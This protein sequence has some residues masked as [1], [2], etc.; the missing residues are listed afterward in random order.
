MST[1]GLG[2]SRIFRRFRRDRTQAIIGRYVVAR[3]GHPLCNV[4]TVFVTNWYRI[5]QLAWMFGFTLGKA[6]GRP[7]RRIGVDEIAAHEFDLKNHMGDI[8]RRRYRFGSLEKIQKAYRIAFFQ[9]KRILRPFSTP[10]LHTLNQCRNLLVHKGGIIDQKFHE[11]VRSVPELKDGPVGSI[12]HFDGELV[13]SLVRA[14]RKASVG[15]L[16]ATDRWLARYPDSIN[17]DALGAARQRQ[18]TA[19]RRE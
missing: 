19:R 9:N 6:A 15:L 2:Y 7:K 3:R 13:C 12:L 5:E 10:Y 16:F 8:L 14:A 4:A 18:R 11:K 1:A 17:L